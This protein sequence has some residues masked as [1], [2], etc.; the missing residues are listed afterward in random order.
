M[1]NLSTAFREK[2]VEKYPLTSLKLVDMQQSE[3][4]EPEISLR[5]SGRQSGGE[6]LDEV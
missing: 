4:T 3:S 2:L 5:P 1:T 6:R